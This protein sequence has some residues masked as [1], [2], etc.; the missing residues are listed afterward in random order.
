MFN[1]INNNIE[2]K[3]GNEAD[4]IQS[5]SDATANINYIKYDTVR[6]HLRSGF[7]FAA[8][9]YEGFLFEVTTERTSGVKNYL[10]QLVYLNTSICID[11]NF[12]K[13]KKIKSKKNFS[14]R[15]T[16]LE[17]DLENKNFT[18]NLLRKI[19]KNLKIDIL[20]NNAGIKF[21]RDFLDYG[22]A[23]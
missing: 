6:L 13:L 11:K 22:N 4:L 10:T 15:I 2:W 20:I 8:R 17:I 1:Y 16:L 18:R 14:N 19:Q 7:S 23:D 5:Q 21:S 12:K 3:G 9:N